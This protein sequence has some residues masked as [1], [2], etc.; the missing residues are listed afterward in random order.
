MRYLIINADDYGFSPQI[1]E[2]VC[3]AY[4]HGI[5]TESSLL[6]YSP[7]AHD[8][9]EQAFEVGL[10]MGIHIDLVT[11]FVDDQGGQFGPNGHF[12]AELYKRERE[13]KIEGLFSAAQLMEIRDQIREQI[14]R[15]VQLVGRLPTHL[16]YHYGLHYLPDVMAIYLIVAEEAGVPVR[17]GDQYAGRS[18]YPLTPCGLCDRF[19]GVESGGV[20]L[21]I[22]LF[23]QH[24]DGVMEFLCH[25]G[26]YTPADLSDLYNREREYELKVLTNPFVKEAL[27]T[28]NIQLVNYDWL[29]SEYARS[30]VRG[31]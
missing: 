27:Q 12:V 28:R 13:K 3:Y 11:P 1:N 31:G 24:W 15:F 16:D 14:D 22:G 21:L 18:V 29:K 23:D 8:G 6:V 20:D 2:G 9:V 19:R 4:Q 17:W 30:K 26:Y 7:Y 25:P 10:P 5:V